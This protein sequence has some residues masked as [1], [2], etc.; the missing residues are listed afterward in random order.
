MSSEAHVKRAIRKVLDSMSIWYYMPPASMYGKGGIPDFVCCLLGR[1]VGIEA[2]RPSVGIKGLS[3]LQLR[4]CH[5][6][7]KNN[8]DYIVVW[9]EDTL[10]KMRDKLIII[11]NSIRRLL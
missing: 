8:G 2:K 3:P 9:N 7:T 6:I 5:E 10:E 1:F 11:S 4:Q